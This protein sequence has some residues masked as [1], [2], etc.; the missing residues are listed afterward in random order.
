MEEMSPFD[1]RLPFFYSCIVHDG[2]G[3]RRA[4]GNLSRAT[5]NAKCNYTLTHGCNNL[6]W[7][8]FVER[9]GVHSSDVPDTQEMT[10][11]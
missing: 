5:L 10:Y 2:Y 4:L 9:M 1:L 3:E 8:N 7:L 6:I 11:S